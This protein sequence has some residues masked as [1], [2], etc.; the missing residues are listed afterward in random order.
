MKVE[1]EAR[2]RC[3]ETTL[4]R[5]LMLKHFTLYCC[6][7]RATC[8]KTDVAKAAS[9]LPVGFTREKKRC[10]CGD[11]FQC[12]LQSENYLADGSNIYQR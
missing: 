4:R 7:K 8:S 2:R 12:F 9:E 10:V 5:V 1:Y 11:Q 6:E 3:L